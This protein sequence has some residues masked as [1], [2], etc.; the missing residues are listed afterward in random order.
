MKKNVFTIC[1]FVLTF[2]LCPIINAATPEL[3]FNCD[4]C[5]S[6]VSS[7]IWIYTGPTASNIYRDALTDGENTHH[8]N[9]TASGGTIIEEPPSSGIYEV[10]DGQTIVDFNYGIVDGY[11]NKINVFTNTDMIGTCNSP[12]GSSHG[13]E[14]Q[15]EIYGTLVVGASMYAGELF[16]DLQANLL[17]NTSWDS[18]SMYLSSNDTINPIYACLDSTNDS[19]IVPVMAGQVID[20]CFNYQGSGNFFQ[21]DSIGSDLDIDIALVPEPCT[22]CLMVLGVLPLVRRRV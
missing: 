3:T 12:Y 4:Y 8:L 21:N 7:S 1:L 14:W 17:S 11:D 19:A 10:I 16:L 18:Y 20:I 9:A 15:V 22:V 6:L 13:G 5:Y 2:S